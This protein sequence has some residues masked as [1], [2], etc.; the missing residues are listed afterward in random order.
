MNLSSWAERIRR[1]LPGRRHSDLRWWD[2]IA[3]QMGPRSVLHHGHSESEIE[4]VT[5]R[6]KSILFPLLRNQLRG[7]EGT[8]LDFGCGP[9][10]FTPGLAELIGG[11]AIGVDPI[12][13]LLDRAPAPPGVQYR[14]VLNGRIPVDDAS[15]D[16]VW[17]CLVLMCITD[18]RALRQAVSEIERVLRPGGLVFLVENTEPRTDLKHLQYRSVEFYQRVFPSVPLQQVGEYQDMGER[19]SVLAGRGGTR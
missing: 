12:R 18:P 8:I 10:R 1:R 6:Q 7:G 5:E 16:V 3:Q 15:I 2:R 14:Q 17:V 13:A 19:I 9:G 11:S 4:E